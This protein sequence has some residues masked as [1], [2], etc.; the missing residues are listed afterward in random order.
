MEKMPLN[1][2]EAAV[3]CAKDEFST[4]LS[5]T[6]TVSSTAQYTVFNN[7]GT[8]FAVPGNLHKLVDAPYC[9]EFDLRF[10]HGSI[11]ITSQRFFTND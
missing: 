11:T 7:R 5:G 4:K 1:F 3:Q 10:N 9:I 2:L 8:I 6:C